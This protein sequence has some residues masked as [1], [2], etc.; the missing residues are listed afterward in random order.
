M[1]R[2]LLLLSTLSTLALNA[3]VFKESFTDGNFNVNPVWSGTANWTIALDGTAGPTAVGSN[4]L[5]LNASAAGN[6]YLSTAN[7][8]WGNFQAW[9]F[10]LGR[11]AVAN[12]QN[13]SIVWLFA[14]RANL[15]DPLI[16]G[17]RISL[18]EPGDDALV[19]ERVT[20]GVPDEIVV[21][22]SEVPNGVTDFGLRVRVT[23]SSLGLWQ[24]FTAI[25]LATIPNG[26]GDD[27]NSSPLA[28]NLNQGA[29]SEVGT[30]IPITGTGYVGFQAIHNAN[31]APQVIAAQF[32]QFFF[33]AN[34]LLPVNFISFTVIKDNDKARLTWNVA[35]EQNV[36]GYEVQRSS[37][38]VQFSKIGYIK[39]AGSPSY[40]FTDEKILNGPN[41]YRIKNVDLDGKFAYTHIVSINGKKG[42]FLKLF[43]I[44]A[45]TDLYI[46]H[47]EAIN[48]AQLKISSMEGRIV[49]VINVAPNAAQT[50]LNLSTMHPGVYFVSY[51]SGD[52]NKFV[53]KFIKQ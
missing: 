42:Q 12:A 35:Q 53:S 34:G 24:I 40:K 28:V 41:F 19:L 6:D 15:S 37:N 50:I 10:W 39:A 9:A 7:T 43:P 38:G 18:G 1:K 32:D 8:N 4:T 31:P 49:K 44:P 5:R 46:Q 16:N 2:V 33:E 51:D 47:H 13:Q 14:D 45:R 29:E 52:G 36:D 17:Y 11:T 21:S 48:G 27:A 23:R 3:Q 26:G 30:P 22:A 20:A 25:N